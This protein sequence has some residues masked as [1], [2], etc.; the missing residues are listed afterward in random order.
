[1]ATFFGRVW[2]YMRYSKSME[3]TGLLFLEIQ[4]N[5]HLLMIMRRRKDGDES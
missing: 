1:M 5:A 2:L 4:T 3:Q